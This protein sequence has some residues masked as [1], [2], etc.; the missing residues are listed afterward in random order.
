MPSGRYPII[1][2]VTANELLRA[3]GALQNMGHIQEE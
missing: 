3:L 2:S 1:D